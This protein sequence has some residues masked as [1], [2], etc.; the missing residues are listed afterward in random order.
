MTETD[1]YPRQ[2]AE[3]RKIA[4]GIFDKDERTAILKLISDYNKLLA[5]EQD[6]KPL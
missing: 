6:N 4:M 5:R 1:A 3:A 2:I